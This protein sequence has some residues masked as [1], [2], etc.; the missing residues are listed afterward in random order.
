M[1]EQTPW[2]TLLDL[3]RRGSRVTGRVHFGAD[4]RCFEGHFPGAPIFPAAAQLQM[5]QEIV[6]RAL[7][8]TVRMRH[9][10]RVKFLGRL[11]PDTEVAFRVDLGE[12]GE[13]RFTLAAG[14]RDISSGTL[15][16]QP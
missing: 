12:A 1:S 5:V 9:L 10:G 16:L 6:G 8:R 11:E 4:L 14:R 3:D 7:G 13:V 2:G 15:Q